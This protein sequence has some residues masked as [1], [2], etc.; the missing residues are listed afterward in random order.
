M[1]TAI[2]IILIIIWLIIIHVKLSEVS[3]SIREIKSSFLKDK[4]Y[5]HRTD[6]KSDNQ[7]PAKKPEEPLSI[8]DIP[9]EVIF[10]KKAD[11]LPQYIENNQKEETPLKDFENMFLGNIFN[12]IG[13]IALLIG[14]MILIKLV[15]PYFVF[16]P[17]LKITLGYLAGIVMM[18]GALKLHQKENMKNYSEVLLGTCF[19]AMFISTYCASAIFELFGFAATAIIA[20]VLLLAAFYLA[21]KLKTIS[22][23]VISLIAA[24]LNPIFLNSEFDVPSN[25]LFGYLIFINL[26]SLVY[27]YRNNSRSI[28]N[29]VN[30]CITFFAAL[31]LCY[32][33]P[34]AGIVTLWAVYIVY[35]LIT[36]SGENK[37]KV[38]NYINLAVLTGLLLDSSWGEYRFIGYTQLGCAVIYAIISYFKKANPEM[39]KNYL[40]MS[41]IAAFLFVYFICNGSPTIKCLV[42]SIEA[43]ILTYFACKYKLK[44]LAGWSCGI[45]AAAYCSILTIDGVLAVKSLANYVPIWNIRLAMFLPIII[46]SAASFWLLN[47]TEDEKIFSVGEFFRFACIS[48]VYL[49]IGLELNNI[50]TQRFIGV[51]TN[52]GF[53]N[54]MINAILFSAYAINIKR[55]HM[56]A[57]SMTVFLLPISAIA[58]ICALILLIFTG[59]HYK[60]IDAFIPVI[61]L[62]FIAFLSGIAASILYRKWT[63]NKVFNYIAI[64]LGF[65]FLHYETVDMITKYAI[66]DGSYLISVSWILYS[67]IITTI[68]ILK[69]KDFFKISG[70]GLCILSILRIFIFDL[71]KV[72]ILYKFIAILTLG[73]ILM[74][75]S[76]L[77][78]KK[79]AK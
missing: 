64:I 59:T 26:L 9:D 52:A 15:S 14:L 38:V 25:F 46:S 73:L 1:V 48:S 60:P 74:I 54:N 37:N 69:N 78:N 47:K 75:L 33:I 4:I 65:I 51:N 5:E 10:N 11:K 36:A 30:L 43:I 29:T 61:N 27:T 55:L 62:R 58:G 70:I 49:Y 42:W 44:M 7:K 2:A 21:D 24:Y 56:I 23:L 18:I 53:I 3:E 19:G 16:T 72:D 31:T 50:I 77:Y 34:Y 57:K 28:T 8:S 6:P 13:S 66:T 20:T 41:L 32:E 40:H 63:D 76:Y 79:S 39:F 71:S 22:M 45:W 35:D 67:G 12:K 17:Q 68:G